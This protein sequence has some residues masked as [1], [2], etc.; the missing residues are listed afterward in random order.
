MKFNFKKR[1]GICKHCGKKMTIYKN[2]MCTICYY[3]TKQDKFAMFPRP[4]T[5]K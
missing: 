2:G 4:R 3:S 1:K 5:Q